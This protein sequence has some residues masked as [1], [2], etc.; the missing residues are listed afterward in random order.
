[1]AVVAL[2]IGAVA[3][4]PLWRTPKL[5]ASGVLIR[6]PGVPELPPADEGRHNLPCPSAE[7]QASHPI[8][9]TVCT[10]VQHPD[11]FACKRIRLRAAFLT[12]CMHHSFLTDAGCERAI[13]PWG[14]P[15]PASD[16]FFEGACASITI[17]RDVKRTATFAGRFRL[18]SEDWGTVYILEIERVENARISGSKSSGRKAG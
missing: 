10:V 1:L 6:R 11:E 7:Q 16:A 14:T 2:A 18:R 4:V 8:E 3:Y 13:E 17:N 9:T 12:D 5:D 15:Y